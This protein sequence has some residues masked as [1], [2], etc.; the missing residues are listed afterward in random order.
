MNQHFALNPDN[1]NADYRAYSIRR[2]S[3]IDGLCLLPQTRRELAGREVR[4]R[5]HAV[6][7]NYRDLM[8]TRGQSGAL[9]QS[10]VPA[11]DG[12]GEVIAIGSEVREFK[13]GDRVVSSF[14]PDW[15][16]GA[17]N[18]D[19]TAR[20]LG[21]TLDGVLAEEVVLPETGWVAIP[22]H[23]DYVEAATLSCAGVTAWNAL[24]CVAPLVP[25]DT[26]LLLGTGGV[27]I[28]ALQLAKAA[29]MKVLITSS[30]DGKL[31]K[32]ITLGADETINYRSTPEWQDEVVRLTK[33]RGVDRVLEVGGPDTLSR[34]IASTRMGGTVS[35]IG[36]LS[37]TAGVSFDPASLFTGAKRMAGVLIGS[38]EMLI[39]LVR[40]IEL[41]RIRP[42]IDKVFDFDQAA[43]AYACLEAAQHF[44]KVV[45]RIPGAEK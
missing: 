22:E 12:A 8:V 20:A 15:Q 43:Q 3:G 24:F 45:I 6:A 37:G 19:S 10:F 21:G 7:L 38:R 34:S 5:M 2:G 36:R 26:I 32:A 11:S 23:L 13:I 33:G 35:V 14:F 42:V 18:V 39:D 1:Q 17:P 44:G 9:E 16:A 4:V 28:W 31:E 27:S 30:D 25:G 40:F 29:G 41:H